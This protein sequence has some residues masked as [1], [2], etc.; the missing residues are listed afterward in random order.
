MKTFNASKK[1]QNGYKKLLK[2]N[3]ST[4]SLYGTDVV[5]DEHKSVVESISKHIIY[6]CARSTSVMS[7]NALAFLLLN[8]FREGA[9]IEQLVTALDNLR[10]ELK[11]GRKDLGFTGD[12]IDVINYGIELLGPGLVRKEKINGEDRIKPVAILPNVIEL[13]YY[14]NTLV[15]HYALESIVAIGINVVA[16]NGAVLH[17]ELVETILDLCNVLQYEFI[18]C[19]PCQNLENEVVGCID[20]LNVK[21]HIFAVEDEVQQDCDKSNKCKN[22][23]KQFEDDEVIEATEKPYTLTNGKT[24]I[25]RLN[26][27]Q[28]LLMPVVETYAISAFTLEKLIGRSL[29]ENEL[30]SDIVNEIKLQ[31]AEGSVKYGK[32]FNFELFF[33]VDTLFQMRVSQLTPS[34]TR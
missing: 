34:K 32:W 13:T 31:L 28:G 26:F 6:D 5:S 30:V 4:T 14:S 16:K 12:S 15:T 19:K 21:Y 3:P 11:T 25:E 23:A 9:T 7:T 20:D 10:D 8:Q 1:I 27:L 22:L 29:M 18:L 33:V 17:S 24:A 2:S